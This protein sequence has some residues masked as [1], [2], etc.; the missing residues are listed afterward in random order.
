MRDPQSYF[1]LQR[2]TMRDKDVIYIANAPTVQIYKFLQL[3]YTFATPA[4]TA[5]VLTQQPGPGDRGRA[6]RVSQRHVPS[7]RPRSR[8]CSIH[9]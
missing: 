8:P 9:R 3:V 2:F 1:A 7:A 4:V 6:D 5:K